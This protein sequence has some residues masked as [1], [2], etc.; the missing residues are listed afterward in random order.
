MLCRILFFILGGF[1]YS[2]DKTVIHEV[3]EVHEEKAFKVF[4]RGLRVLSG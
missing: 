2:K 4:F 1:A 3:H